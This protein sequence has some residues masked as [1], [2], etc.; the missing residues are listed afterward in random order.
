MNISFTEQQEEYITQQ[1]KSG[2]FQN[3]SE[4]V[5]DALRLHILYR[6][7]VISE[8]RAEIEKGW[9]APD[10]DKTIEDIINEKIRLNG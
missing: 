6:N 4:V 1:V 9:D 10:S 8:L 7:K 3:Q 5:R 2:E